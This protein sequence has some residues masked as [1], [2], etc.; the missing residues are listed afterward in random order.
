M[1][2]IKTTTYVLKAPFSLSLAVLSDMHNRPVPMDGLRSDPPDLFLLPG[3]V[4]D[5]SFA[6]GDQLILDR[7]PLVL[8]FLQECARIAPTYLSLGNHEYKLAPEDLSLIRDTGVT[9]LDDAFVR[10]GNAVIGG[11]TSGAV[12]QY[13]FFRS[14]SG[15]AERYPTFP[16]EYRKT[17]LKQPRLDWLSAYEA[18]EGYHILLCH[19]PDYWEPFLSSRPI[20]LTVSG[21]AHGGQVRLFGRGLFAPDQGFFPRYTSGLETGS[22]GGTLLISRGLS[23]PV[24]LPR[25]FNP[26]EIVRVRLSP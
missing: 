20:D 12:H 17:S 7:N 26:R 22:A 5:R 6:D 13:R 4:I 24:L 9:L 10:H 19:H 14:R 11:L 25:L 21:H 3:D 18:E 8:P 15:S 2:P 16:D 1:I 23:N